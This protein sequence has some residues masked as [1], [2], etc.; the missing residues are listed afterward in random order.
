MKIYPNEIDIG[1][2]E[3]RHRD[4]KER[5]QR[6]KELRNAINIKLCLIIYWQHTTECISRDGNL[7]IFKLK[8]TT[9][10]LLLLMKNHRVERNF[11]FHLK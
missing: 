9:P 6:E 1:D 3:R 2:Q 7:N 8:G 10:C 4:R 11:C 5:V